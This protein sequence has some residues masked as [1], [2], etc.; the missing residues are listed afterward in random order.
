MGEDVVVGRPADPVAQGSMR[1][2]SESNLLDPYC[3]EDPGPDLDSPRIVSLSSTSFLFFLITSASVTV[4]VMVYK[5]KTDKDK[6]S[7]VKLTMRLSGF[8]DVEPLNQSNLKPNLAP[9]RSIKETE[10]RKGDMIGSGFGGTVYQGLWYPDG[11]EHKD[12]TP[13]AIKVLRDDGQPNMNKEFLDE[14]YIMASVNHP[15]LVKLLAVCMTPSQLILVTPLMPIG[16]LLDYVQKNQREITSKNLLEWGKQIAKGMAYL[17][18]RRMVHRDLALRNVLLQTKHRALISDFGLAKFLDVDQNEYKVA[19]SGGPRLPI[20]WLA[21]ECIRERKFTHKS[22]VWAFGVTVWELVT[23]GDRPYKKYTTRAICD[24]IEK[25]HRLEQPSHVS[26]DVYKE[27]YS[28]WFYNPDLRPN[29]ESLAK[30]FCNFARDPERYLI[31]NSDVLVRNSE[32]DEND[33]NDEYDSESNSIE[34]EVSTPQSIQTPG[35]QHNNNVNQTPTEFE[36]TTRHHHSESETPTFFTNMSRYPN[37]H[38]RTC[39]D[40]FSRS[41]RQMSNKSS[42]GTIT[43]PNNNNNVNRNKN[44]NNFTS[45]ILDGQGVSQ[46]NADSCWTVDHTVSTNSLGQRS[47]QPTDLEDYLLPSPCSNEDKF[48]KWPL[49]N[50]RN[51]GSRLPPRPPSSNDPPHSAGLIGI[52]NQEYF[53]THRDYGYSNGATNA[54]SGHIPQSLV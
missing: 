27:M 18:E 42:N 52:S 36:F 48:S 10:L 37:L 11:Q 40:V 16:C 15:N 54:S 47:V 9:L 7:T 39:D 6:M 8:D 45:D 5:C 33:C 13:V 38:H 14:A 12:P 50:E 26:V 17:E 41:T 20:K 31:C 28:C 35:H 46:I 51:L 24:I 25:G 3:S 1:S 34:E 32:S 2:C 22:D 44:N 43:D 29:F 53:L 21:P 19:P 49:L 30:T 23:F 4:C